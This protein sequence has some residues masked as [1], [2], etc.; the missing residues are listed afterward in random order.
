ME[1]AH[2]YL[3]PRALVPA[4]EI[5]VDDTLHFTLDIHFRLDTTLYIARPAA[6]CN[7]CKMGLGCACC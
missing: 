3:V 1:F 6:L 7:A 4:A 2:A 5:A